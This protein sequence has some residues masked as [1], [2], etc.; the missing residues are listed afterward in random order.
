MKVYDKA[1]WHNNGEN[2]E[3]NVKAYFQNLME[4]LLKNN[5][6]SEDGREILDIGIDNDFSLNSK[7]VN[8]KGN[9]FLGKNYDE[10]L[11][12]IDF[13]NKISIDNIDKFFKQ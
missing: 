10:I 1:K 5:M 13:N 8:E 6:L 11:S 7:L 9:L 4:L 12:S 2:N 3:L